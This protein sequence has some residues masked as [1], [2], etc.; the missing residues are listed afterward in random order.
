MPPTFRPP[1]STSL[2]RETSP[3][4][5]AAYNAAPNGLQTGF[6]LGAVAVPSDAQYA[7]Q[8]PQPY[9]NSGGYPYDHFTVPAAKRRKVSLPKSAA[10]PVTSPISK[11]GKK[12]AQVKEM[13]TSTGVPAK[14]RR[15]R[16]GCLTCRERHLKCDEGTPDCLNC[17]KSNRECKRGVRLNFIDMTC[18][19]PP[20][21]PPTE[22]WSG[23]LLSWASLHGNTN[24]FLP[25]PISR[26][27]E[28]HCIRVSRRTWEVY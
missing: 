14:S 27:V 3:A 5:L 11:S 13:P 8:R 23:R 20:Y 12:P 2:A 7:D 26:R 15:V 24:L 25:S 18:K 21:I 1:N 9:A 22:E 17:K 6:T 19:E 10:A 16:T 28:A 4:T